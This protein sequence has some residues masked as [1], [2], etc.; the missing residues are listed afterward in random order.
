[1]RDIVTGICSHALAPL[2]LYLIPLVVLLFVIEQPLAT[3][4]EGE[5]AA[6]PHGICG[7][8][9]AVLAAG[10]IAARDS[11]TGGMTEPART[12]AGPG[13]GTTTGT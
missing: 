1:M 2:F 5:V 12:S 7:G 11:D 10:A 9:D 13:A 3:T 6:Q 4:T 8:D